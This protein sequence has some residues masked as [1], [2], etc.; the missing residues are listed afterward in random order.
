MQTTDIIETT[1]QLIAIPSTSDNPAALQEA[2]D[3]LIEIIAKV[4]GVTIERFNSKYRPSILAYYGETRP[5]KF[6]IILNAHLD[7]VP[8]TP[9]QFKPVVK[10]GKLY[11]RGALDMKGTAAS[12]ASLF[13]EL[14]PTVP[15]ALGLQ[16]VTDEEIGGYDGVRHHID[17][18]INADF[19]IM[20]EYSN[21]RN[22]IYN[23]ARGLCWAEIKF[24]GKT[25]HGGHLWHGTNAV[26]K[27]GDFAGAVLKHYPTPDKETWTTTANIANL[28]TPNDTYNK[29]PD[30]AVLKIDFRFT[31]EDPVFHTR[32]SVEAFIK[33]LDPD[34]ELTNLFT[35][36]PAVNVEEL[37]PYVVGLS[38]AIKQVSGAKPAFLGRPAASDGRHYAMIGTD[39]IEYGL[40]GHGPHSDLECVELA[41]FEEYRSVMTAFLQRPKIIAKPKTKPAAKADFTSLGLLRQLVAMPTITGN[42]DANNAALLF[43]EQ[44]LQQRGMHITRFEQGGV[45]SLLAT[46]RPGNLKPAV[47]LNAHID[48]VPAGPEHFNLTIDGDMLHGRGVMDMKFAIASYLALVDDLKDKLD[49]YDFGILIT[50]DEEVGGRNGVNIVVNEHNLQ[51]KVAIVP[52]GGENWEI[53]TFAKGV[54]WIKLEAT[55]VSGHA[56]RPWEGHSAI[57]ALLGALRDIE[58]LMP[59]SSDRTATHLS[60][61]TIA[62]GTTG[63]Q[64]AATAAALLDIRYG[65]L[66]DY[67]RMYPLIQAICEQHDVSQTLLVSDQPAINDV[68]NPYIKAFRS[69][70]TTVTGTTFGTSYSFGASDGRYFSALSIPTI[71]VLPPSGGRHTDA[72]WLSLKGFKQFS[73]ILGQ[74]VD[75]F[76]RIPSAKSRPHSPKS[77][78]W[79]VTYGS[80]ISGEIFKC[81][82]RGGLPEGALKAYPGCRDTTAPLKNKFMA[83]PHALYFGGESTTWGGGMAFVDPRQDE[84]AHT[85]SRA[86]LITEDQF[87][88]IVA[89][90]NHQ[91]LISP[92]PL[93]K[94]IQNGEAV[95]GNGAGDYSLLL[96]CG[97]MDGHPM[98]TLTA[99]TPRPASAPS[100]S[101]ARMLYKGL[102]QN[103]TLDAKATMDYMMSKTDISGSYKE[104]DILNLSEK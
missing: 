46:T 13:C 96:Y 92:L 55:G 86:H 76:A 100:P 15:Y 40:Y 102:S 24:T 93:E 36:E 48:V 75:Q 97:T 67:H 82:I 65:S 88:D 32:E 31:Q 47:L 57:H 81:F 22:T 7:V 54:Q 34:A 26:I 66:D 53:E 16:L 64:I 44:Y 39:I 43:I 35:Y 95:I 37:N 84:T 52:D 29:V 99:A 61:G 62:G 21:A 1:K 28:S 104:Q 87:E 59:P 74:Y 50:A 91:S 9:E 63:N 38:S 14:A 77:H 27:A 56:S 17:R 58:Q 51:P 79:Y 83:L 8:G 3:V 4:P 89:Q 12:L 103:K 78:L 2:L 101:Y 30:S 20:G 71:T 85:I 19:V 70:I 25:A 80:G 10:D 33:S 94:A 11:G 42:H 90:Q 41:S 60:I 18:G 68:R 49:A 23:A 73:T 98:F 5:E 45:G 6:D 72:E 69:L